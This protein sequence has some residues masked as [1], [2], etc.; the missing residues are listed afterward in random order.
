[1]VLFL[2]SIL[3]MGSLQAQQAVVSAGQ[4]INGANYSMSNST[5]LPDFMYYQNDQGIV[6]FGVQQRNPSIPISDYSVYLVITLILCTIIYRYHRQINLTI[7][8]KQS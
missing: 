4:E 7:K 1:M 8:T 3:L 5:G 2:T 6:Q